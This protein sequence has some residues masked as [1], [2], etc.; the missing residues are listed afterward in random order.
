MPRID[1]MLD[2]LCGK[3]FFTML[4]PK[5]GYWQV[6]MDES[7]KEKTAFST[8]TGLCQFRV[9]PFSLCNVPATFQRD[10]QHIL[11]GLG[12]SSPFCFAYIDDILVFS[13]TLEQHRVHLQ[14]V[15]ECLRSA[16]LLLHSKKCIYLS[17]IISDDGIQP[18]STKITMV[19]SLSADC[20]CKFMT[21][22][23]L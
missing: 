16:G 15:F 11:S 7:S 9:M 19:C 22:I 21:G 1:N 17:H 4:D 6:Q 13:N 2:Q 10:I 23:T 20:S 5:F 14:Q 12:G 3:Q 18:D 8:S